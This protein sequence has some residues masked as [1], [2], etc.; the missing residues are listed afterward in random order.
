MGA[1]RAA[2]PGGLEPRGAWVA[3]GTAFALVGAVDLVL[4][5]RQRALATAWAPLERR[6]SA[7]AAGWSA[8]AGRSATDVVPGA[9]P[10]GPVLAPPGGPQ[11]RER[12]LVRRLGMVL[13]GL[14]GVLL[15]IGGGVGYLRDAAAAEAFRARAQTTTATIHEVADD[16]FAGLV[17]IEGVVYRVPYFGTTALVDEVVPV[18]YDPGSGRAELVEDAF[19]PSGAIFLVGA[20]AV[21]GA[22]L[23]GSERR[24]R[25]R[26]GAFMATGGR[27]L[28]V[29]ATTT[30]AGVVRLAPI[31]APGRPFVAF[32]RGV[33]VPE[34]PGAD[35]SAEDAQTDVKRRLRAWFG[36]PAF[37]AESARPEPVWSWWTAQPVELVGLVADGEPAA[38]R[39]PDGLWVVAT[40]GL[41]DPRTLRGLISRAAGERPAVGPGSLWEGFWLGVER[42]VRRFAARTGSFLPWLVAPAVGLLIQWS[43]SSPDVR[44]LHGILFIACA[45]WWGHAWAFP[46]FPRLHLGHGAVSVRGVVVSRVIPWRDVAAVLGEGNALALGLRTTPEE[47]VHIVRRHAERSTPLLPG[48]PPVAEV[49]E[50]MER[51]RRAAESASPEAVPPASVPPVQWRRR[52]T[53]PAIVGAWWLSCATT[54]LLLAS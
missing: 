2:Q 38:I 4:V 3:A 40:C 14:A 26:V 46:A 45:G 47:I 36:V 37:A 41:E 1:P 25:R 11:V 54:G 17:R 32:R 31:D 23:L 30:L 6:W 8:D 19:D 5:V 15:A 43:W 39:G 49:R 35:R 33:S 42:R 21:I 24:R 53:P 51:A 44:G 18:R 13:G 28:T 27:P 9:L 10:A 48:D 16:G 34:E 12:L 29:L 52:L 22:T 50:R 7:D 20:G